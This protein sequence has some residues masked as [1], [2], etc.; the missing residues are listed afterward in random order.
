[1]G[2]I[3]L[4]IAAVG[5]SQQHGIGIF[6]QPILLWM[7]DHRD[8][9]LTQ[10]ALGITTLASPLSLT[11]IS[12]V[13]FIIWVALRHEWQRPLLFIGSLGFTAILS[14]SIKCLTMVLR[15]AQI[16]MIAP[17]ETDYSFPSGHTLGA[18]VFLLV[19]GYL[20]YS[21]DFTPKRLCVWSIFALVG[22]TITAL[23]RLYLGYH[24]LTDTVASFGVSLIILSGVI[25]VDETTRKF[26]T[27][28]EQSPHAE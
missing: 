11:V 25:F 5:A 6:D 28:S 4:V 1:M 17:F 8:L 22:A 26:N 12:L 10:L 3:F 24:W 13:I 16:Y 2:V 14:L 21:R 18:M 27:R 23:S 9:F 19:L 15:P 20:I 7:F